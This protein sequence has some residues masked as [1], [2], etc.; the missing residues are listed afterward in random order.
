MK[1]PKP[2][3]SK[4][5]MAF[6]T[7]GVAMF[8]SDCE[9]HK[10]GPNVVFILVDDLGYNDLS[11]NGN[12]IFETP[13][14]DALAKMGVTFENAY[15]SPLCTPT[16][17]ALMTG[18]YPA[19]L[20][21]TRVGFEYDRGE[22]LEP[23]YY[24]PATRQKPE[25]LWDELSVPIRTNLPQE[26]MTLAELAKNQGY[27][28]GFVGKWHLGFDGSYP[29]NHGFDYCFG[30]DHWTNYF[31]PWT[32]VRCKDYTS[33]PGE[34]ITDRLGT[35]AV[36]F[37]ERNKNDKFFLSLWTY[38]I[39]APIEGKKELVEK[40]SAKL[41]GNDEYSPVYG[42]M[43][44]SEDNIIG[45]VINALKDNN[46]LENTLVVFMSD[47]GPIR[48]M[49]FNKIYDP[50]YNLNNN[51]ANS[52]VQLKGQNQLIQGFRSELDT[53][54]IG[55][56]IGEVDLKNDDSILKA[57]IYDVKNS[58]IIFEKKFN[59]NTINPDG[60]YYLE[61][62][63]GTNSEVF[64]LKLSL[65]GNKN[66]TYLVFKSTNDD[67]ILNESLRYNDSILKGDLCIRLSDTDINSS[68]NVKLTDLNSLKGSKLTVYEGGIKVPL[69]FVW[70]GAIEN[71]RS[72]TTPVA[73]IDVMPT[74]SSF[75]GGQLTHDIDGL[76]L[77]DLILE[78]EPIE[79]REL[80]WHYPHYMF[81]HGAEVVRDD[82]FK[83]IEFYKNGRK[84]LYDLSLDPGEKHNLFNENPEKVKELK[85]KLHTWLKN[86]NA[87]LPK[88]NSPKIPS[89]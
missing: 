6:I 8:F 74:I 45:R 42:A 3:K 14:I 20:K 38:G 44:E 88:K 78:N 26:E 21:M 63:A 12:P 27:K 68:E 60:W 72:I 89:I 76:S 39:H 82:R 85:N 34:H 13:N 36:N 59:F 11:V 16:R 53:F 54:N 80:Y 25:D 2:V 15:S 10:D 77:Y 83:Y 37:I 9:E 75:M 65:D 31:A 17:A 5:A 64:Q 23:G 33:F 55:F 51:T 29:E 40:Y 4:V 47:N 28:T 87:S 56:S 18:K 7:L 69:F 52:T 57:E 62:V 19:R 32:G 43:L 71:G 22:A 58:K 66:D 48:Q 79:K 70:P 49:P 41:D 81:S 73:H 67:S 35:E 24:H 50:R 46:L 30:G 61:A 1:C 84:E 86:S